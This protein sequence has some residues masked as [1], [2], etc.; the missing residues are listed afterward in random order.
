MLNSFSQE[1]EANELSKRA[2]AIADVS[3]ALRECRLKTALVLRM[4]P[5]QSIGG[6]IASLANVDD[7]RIEYVTLP[8]GH[9][10]ETI[11]ETTRGKTYDLIV[12]AF[13]L[14]HLAKEEEFYAAQALGDGLSP[15]GVFVTVDYTLPSD[16]AQVVPYITGAR[17]L[18]NVEAYGGI[19]RWFPAH[20]GWSTQRLAQL[21]R[22]A[23]RS[24]AFSNALP[25][26]ASIAAASDNLETIDMIQRALVDYG[27][28][29]RS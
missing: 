23:E 14:H 18:E 13:E 21:A 8:A 9:A 15:G 26:H 5:T 2:S 4:H 10:V 3:S 17:E 22:S 24:F 16:P 1:R 6:S 20:A 12:A 19:D 29:P 11:K 28:T 25:A 27:V 7:R